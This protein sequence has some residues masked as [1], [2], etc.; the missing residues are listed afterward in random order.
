MESQRVTEAWEFYRDN[1]PGFK[2]PMRKRL[3]KLDKYVA[4]LESENASLRGAAMGLGNECARLRTDNARLRMLLSG[5]LTTISW[6]TLDSCPSDSKKKELYDSARELG[7]DPWS[8]S[9][10]MT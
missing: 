9:R 4:G 1:C 10:G 3:R 7:V 2:E 5:A 6:C 8:D